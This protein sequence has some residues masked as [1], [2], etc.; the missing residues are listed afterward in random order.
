MPA[1]GVEPARVISPL[2]F[3]S[4]T[5][6]NSITP[7]DL[8]RWPGTQYTTLCRGLQAK[9]LSDRRPAAA[10]GKARGGERV[11][12]NKTAL[13]PSGQNGRCWPRRGTGRSIGTQR[14]PCRRTDASLMTCHYMVSI[15]KIGEV[16]SPIGGKRPPCGQKT[17]PESGCRT[18]FRIL[19]KL[20]DKRLAPWYNTQAKGN[21][22]YRGVEQFGSSSGS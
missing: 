5:S 13:P 20:L 22:R 3:E 4:N 11:N 2:D 1:A 6:A 15:A 18:I 17:G 9:L 12:P 21:K 19:R 16:K 14:R 7:A 10:G 8:R